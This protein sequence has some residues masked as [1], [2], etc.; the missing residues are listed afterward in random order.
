VRH[1][2][3]CQFE[4]RLGTTACPDCG[5]A[6][7]V[8]PLPEPSSGPQ[9]RAVRLVTLATVADPSVADI[10]RAVLAEAGITA[11]IRRHGPITGELGRVT[12]GL[13]EDYAVVVVPE[14]RLAEAERL[15]SDLESRSFEWPEGMTPDD[16]PSGSSA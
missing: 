5:G 6:L 10:L 13:T 14:N 7:V 2:P 15:L 4:Y 8:G 12:D 16:S 3:N 9:S 11:H 1:C